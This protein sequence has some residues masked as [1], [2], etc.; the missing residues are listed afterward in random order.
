MLYAS[1]VGLYLE[2]AYENPAIPPFNPSLI[3]R[4]LISPLLPCMGTNLPTCLKQVA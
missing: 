1:S 3:G 4:Q 2:K